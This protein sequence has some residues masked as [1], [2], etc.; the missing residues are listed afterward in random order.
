MNSKVKDYLVLLGVA[1]AMATVMGGLGPL[2]PPALLVPIPLGAARLRSRGY[3]QSAVLA[4]EVGRRYGLPVASDLLSRIR[5]TS[6]QTALTPE[7]RT[8][9]LVE[10]SAARE[11]ES[12]ARHVPTSP[13]P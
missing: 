9:V 12:R 1:G 3:N 2:R 11:R 8:G 4:S 10:L 7:E 5:E 13:T 6:T